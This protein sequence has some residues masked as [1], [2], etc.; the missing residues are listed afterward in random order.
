MM[1]DHPWDVFTWLLLGAILAAGYAL[2][3]KA[4]QRPA[5]AL[6]WGTAGGAIWGFVLAA[7]LTLP[8]L[9]PPVDTPGIIGLFIFLILA[10]TAGAIAMLATTIVVWSLRRRWLYR[11]CAGLAAAAVLAATI[12]LLSRL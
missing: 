12:V 8:F 2:A 9:P 10:G 6:L 11:F 5:L 4:I 1:P 3:G 7:S